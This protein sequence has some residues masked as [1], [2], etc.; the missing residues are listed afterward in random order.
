[1]APDPTLLTDLP[2]PL[3]AYPDS[4]GQAL[5]HTL[6]TRVG[7]EPFNAIATAIFVLAILHTFTTAQFAALA[8]RVQHRQDEEAR[9]AGR[10]VAPSVK[11][12]MLHFLG[13]VEVVFGLWAVVLLILGILGAGVLA[14]W[15]RPAKPAATVP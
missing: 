11:A 13:E 4:T 10:A 8:H 12:E 15:L 5:S 6:A 2:L 7:I 14:S 1:M 3:T 9:A